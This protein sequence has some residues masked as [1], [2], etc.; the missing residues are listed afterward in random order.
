MSAREAETDQRQHDAGD[1]GRGDAQLT[2]R[3]R[4]EALGGV[5]P[6]GVDVEQVVPEVDAA[7]GEA[8]RHE[9]D[10]REDQFVAL[11]E[12]AGGAGRGEHED[13]LQPLLRP[14]F[15]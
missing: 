11:I 15:A 6:V 1:P 4:P 12:D 14:R 2:G 5:E 13:V 3:D 9:R 10:D 7:G 8:E